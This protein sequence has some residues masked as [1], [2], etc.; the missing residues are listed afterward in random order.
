LQP[1]GQRYN[2]INP[3]MAV[4]ELFRIQNSNPEGFFQGSGGRS[5]VRSGATITFDGQFPS[6]A[7]VTNGKVLTLSDQGEA[8]EFEVDGNDSITI[9]LETGLAKP[10]PPSRR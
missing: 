10:K 3:N 1:V 7:T 2:Q 6:I 4:F 8:T 5:G 9:D